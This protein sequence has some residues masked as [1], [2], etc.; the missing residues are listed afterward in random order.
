MRSTLSDNLLKI[1][2]HNVFSAI[3][4][5]ESLRVFMQ[6][7]VFAVWDFMSLVKRL[8]R[9][10]TCVT[11]PW[12]P[13]VHQAAARL[14]NEIVLGEETDECSDGKRHKSH[15][16]IYIEAMREIGAN[17]SQIEKFIAYIQRT[18]DVPGALDE[19]HA[20]APIRRF[21]LHTMNVAINGSIEDVLGAFFYGREDV[22]PEMFQSLLD[23]WT[24]E[25][26]K[27]PTFVYYLQRHIELDGDSHG[28]AAQKMISEIIGNNNERESALLLSA[29]Y[30]VIERHNLWD[31]LFN[32]L[33]QQKEEL[34]E[35]L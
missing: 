26:D 31:G 14:I 15:F 18:G 8:Q 20:S 25:P 27:A 7:H 24:V 32:C 28:P 1:K 29:N 30:A 34:S 12:I 17:T 11:L 33:S 35:R 3:R 2:H 19:V 23:N 5:I 13:P 9:D 6:W 4:D 10:L 21:V 22:I 16:E